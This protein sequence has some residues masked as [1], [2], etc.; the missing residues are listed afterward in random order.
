[1]VVEPLNFEQ[2]ALANFE[3]RLVTLQKQ[4]AKTGSVGTQQQ[5]C[6]WSPGAPAAPF[7]EAAQALVFA[8]GS[9]RDSF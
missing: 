7:V 9:Q 5:S 4:I 6:L 8:L 1:M 2:Q 3:Q